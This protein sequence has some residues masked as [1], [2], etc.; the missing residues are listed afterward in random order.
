MKIDTPAE[1]ICVMAISAPKSLNA[2]NSQVL[3]EIDHYVSNIDTSAIRVLVVTGDGDRSFVAGADISEMANLNEQGATN[4]AGLVLLSSARSKRCP[5]Q[6][7][8]R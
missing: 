2:L 3:R 8:L 5:Y 7:L 6:L 1:G 4:L